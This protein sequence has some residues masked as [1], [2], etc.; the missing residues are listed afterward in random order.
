M[1][2]TSGD[3]D[4]E[5]DAEVNAEVNARGLRCPIP[6]IRLGAALRD[7]SPGSTVRLLATDPAA[8]TDVAAFCR[9]RG[10]RLADVSEV[11]AV[12]RRS[13]QEPDSPAYTV[14]LVERGD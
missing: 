10:H 14:Y 4:A 12:Q 2:D 1:T 13:D 6:V 5:V 7:L 9:M 3:L 8:R 11:S